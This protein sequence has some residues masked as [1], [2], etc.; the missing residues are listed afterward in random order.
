LT[1]VYKFAQAYAAI[2]TA[3][4]TIVT[5][6]DAAELVEEPI[7][8]ANQHRSPALGMFADSIQV[9]GGTAAAPEWTGFVI[10]QIF[11]SG[12]GSVQRA[13]IIELMAKLEHAFLSHVPTDGTAYGVIG[14]PD[15][16]FWYS[17]PRELILAG[18]FGSVPVKMQGPLMVEEED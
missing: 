17:D 13:K 1:T 16:H 11:A 5:A 14:M 9:S 15:L 8:P 12:K 3:L 7:S 4:A 6:G 2:K 10:V 18:A